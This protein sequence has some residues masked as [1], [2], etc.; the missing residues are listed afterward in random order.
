M[1]KLLS[2]LLVLAL[3]LP[4]ASALCDDDPIVGAWYVMFDYKTYPDQSSVVGKDRMIYIL[5]F[6]PDGTIIGM[7]MDKPVTGDADLQ[8]D[9]LGT[10]TNSSGSYSLSIIGMGTSGAQFSGDRLEVQ[11]MSNVWYSMQ[12]MNMSDWYTDLIVRLE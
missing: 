10:W 1:K 3:L 12:R 2:L 8:Y 7:T 9:V 5:F 6:E 11:M 4:A